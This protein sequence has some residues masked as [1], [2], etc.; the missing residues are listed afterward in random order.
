[1]KTQM[2]QKKKKMGKK[3]KNPTKLENKNHLLE[4]CV[5]PTGNGKSLSIYVFLYSYFYF[6]THL[7]KTPI[8]I[9]TQQ[10]ISHHRYY[11]SSSHTCHL[12]KTQL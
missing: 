1:M 9:Y 3:G 4:V 7:K 6:Y 12:C 5:Q 10:I 2:V 11:N 8:Y